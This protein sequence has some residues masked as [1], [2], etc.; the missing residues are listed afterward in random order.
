MVSN[1]EGLIRPVEFCIGFLK[2]R[3]PEFFL[4]VR[5]HENQLAIPEDKEDVFL[6]VFLGS[7]GESFDLVGSRS[8]TTTSTHSPYCQNLKREW[9]QCIAIVIAIIIIIHHSPK[10]TT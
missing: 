9:N 2:E 6:C 7:F 4:R 10:Q 5:L 3:R 1:L 8:S